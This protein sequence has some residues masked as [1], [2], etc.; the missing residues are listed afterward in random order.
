[1][2]SPLFVDTITRTTRA[3]C[4]FDSRSSRFRWPPVILTHAQICMMACVYIGMNWNA[5]TVVRKLLILKV[6][7]LLYRMESRTY[8][9]LTL[10]IHEFKEKSKLQQLLHFFTIISFTSRLAATAPVTM[11]RIGTAIPITEGNVQQIVN[12]HNLFRSKADPPASNVVSKTICSFCM[13]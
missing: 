12:A 5:E 13:S 11:V 10:T 2:R 3:L 4:G 8:S 1:M 6:S 7:E 9:R